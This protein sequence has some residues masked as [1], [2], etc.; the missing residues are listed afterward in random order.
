MR[1]GDGSEGQGGADRGIELAHRP[2]HTA[3]AVGRGLRDR[4]ERVRRAAAARGVAVGDRRGPRCAATTGFRRRRGI[5]LP[6]STTCSASAGGT[7][8]WSID[9]INRRLCTQR[10]GTA[11]T[12]GSSAT[13]ACSIREHNPGLAVPARGHRRLRNSGVRGRQASHDPTQLWQLQGWRWRLG[14]FR[15]AVWAF[16]RKDDLPLASH[17]SSTGGIR[18]IARRRDGDLRRDETKCCPQRAP[19]AAA[20]VVA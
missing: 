16:P 4:A 18:P 19:V 8:P 17:R 11:R 7:L 13:P 3:S 5:R 1:G 14:V 6:W 10:S 12:S 9:A 2:W 20:D 15:H